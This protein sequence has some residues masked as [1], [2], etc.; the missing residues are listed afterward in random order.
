MEAVYIFTLALANKQEAR[1][2][3]FWKKVEDEN[4]IPQRT[5]ESM[6]SFWK[7]NSNK[8]LEQYLKKAIDD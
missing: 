6:R 8:G 5:C 3:S 1:G 4:L 2:A 7:D